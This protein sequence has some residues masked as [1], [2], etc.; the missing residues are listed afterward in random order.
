MSEYVIPADASREMLRRMI[1]ETEEKLVAQRRLID[2]ADTNAPA[3]LPGLE[4]KERRLAEH[5]QRLETRL[6]T[7]T[8]EGMEGTVAAHKQEIEN[9]KVTSDR[10]GKEIGQVVD[11]VTFLEAFCLQLRDQLDKVDNTQRRQN[12]MVYG[13]EVGEPWAVAQELFKN[14][15]EFVPEV[16]DVFFVKQE[17][18]K[19]HPFKIQFKLLTAARNFLDWSGGAEFK[20]QFPHC[21]AERDVTTL[22]RV[23]SSRLSAAAEAIRTEFDGAHITPAASFLKYK[24]RKY[25]AIEFAA[26]AIVT[27]GSTSAST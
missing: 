11:R 22:R 6:S 16:D 12:A 18:G 15:A 5:L 23:G 19:K 25:D 26:A 24:G 10:Q 13:F 20:E 4:R 1:Q 7:T 3:E 9:L 14:K 17:P 8:T 21:G 2:A 27:T